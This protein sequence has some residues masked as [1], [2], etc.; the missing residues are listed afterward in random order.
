MSDFILK[1]FPVDKVSVDKIEL[2]KE[3]FTKAEFLSGK[4][5]EFSGESYLEPGQSFCDYFEF[6]DENY[7]RQT[8]KGE[9]KTK[10]VAHVY[11]MTM[12]EDAEEPEFIDR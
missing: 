12:E 11:G 10:I 8:F 3:H 7:A 9:A 2:I 4:E 5:T 1:I 6:E